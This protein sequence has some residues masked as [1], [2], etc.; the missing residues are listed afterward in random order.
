[1]ATTPDPALDLTLVD[2]VAVIGFDRQAG[3]EV[4]LTAESVAELSGSHSERSKAPL[5]RAYKSTILQVFPRTRTGFPF[6]PEVASLCMPKGLQFF[7]ERKLPDARFHSFVLVREDGTRL[8]GCAFTFYEP[9]LDPEIRQQMFD[10]HLDYIKDV[11]ESE[12]PERHSRVG[13]PDRSS[14]QPGQVSFGQHTLPRN[15]SRRNQSKRTS[16]YDSTNKPIFVAKCLCVLQR[17][18]ILFS[19]ENILLSLYRSVL[20]SR[21]PPNERVDPVALIRW[22]L[23]ELPLPIPGT[24]LQCSYF[25]CDLSVR[26]PGLCELPFFDYPIFELFKIIPVEKL[27]KLFTCFMLEHQILLCSKRLDRLML[28]AECLSTLIFPFRWQL[29]YVPVLP[30]AQLKFI[31]APVPYLMGFCYDDRIPDQIFQ[32][33]VCVL[34]IDARR[35]DHPEDVPAFP[36]AREL[37]AQIEELVQNFDETAADEPFKRAEVPAK[38]RPSSRRLPSTSSCDR[39]P[40]AAAHTREIAA[41]S[42]AGDAQNGGTNGQIDPQWSFKRMSRSFDNSEAIEA[43]MR[44]EV[45]AANEE[46]DAEEAGAAQ[47][48]RVITNARNEKIQRYLNCLAFNSAIR[49]LFLHTFVGLFTS[50]EQ[51][52]AEARQRMGAAQ[53]RASVVVRPVDFNVHEIPKSRPSFVYDVPPPS[54]H[55]AEGYALDLAPNGVFPQFD[56]SLFEAPPLPPPHGAQ[57]RSDSLHPNAN[58]QQAARLAAEL[59]EQR[60]KLRIAASPQKRTPKRR[61]AAAALASGSVQG[62]TNGATPNAATPAQLAH[63][64]WT[65]VEQLLKE[66]KV[67]TKRLLLMKMGKEA[68]QLGHH[69]SGVQGVEE[70]T[71]VAGFCDLLDR[72][73]SSLWANVLSFYEQNKFEEVRSIHKHHPNVSPGTFPSFISTSPPQPSVLWERATRTRTFDRSGRPLEDDEETPADRNAITEIFDSFRSMAANWEKEV[74]DDPTNA[75]TWS[76]SLA[77]VGNFINKLN[78]PLAPPTTGGDFCTLPRPNFGPPWT[79]QKP[80]PSAR[81]ERSD[82]QLHAGSNPP[83]PTAPS[84][85]HSPLAVAAER[86]HE[87]KRSLSRPKSPAYDSERDL[88]PL[89]T[90]IGYDLRNVLRMTEIKTDIGFARAFVRLSLERKLL[91]SHLKAILSDRSLLRELYKRY[92][93]LRSEDER[94][95]FLYHVLS[96]NA[97]DFSCF[98]HTFISTRIQYEVL[99]VS[100]L[101]RFNSAAVW[102]I[103]SGSLGATNTINL[104]PNSLQF[105]FEHKNLGLLTTLR[106]GYNV[107]EKGAKWFLDY[108]IVRNN[109]TAQAFRFNCGRSFGRGVDDG[110]TERVLV[111]ETMRK[112]AARGPDDD[113]SPVGPPAQNMMSKWMSTSMMLNQLGATGLSSGSRPQSP[114]GSVVSEA[115]GRRRSASRTH[116]HRSR[117]PSN[118]PAQQRQ[119][120]NPQPQYNYY[121]ARGHRSELQLNQWDVRVNELQH[122]IGE[123]VN[124]LVKHFLQNTYRSDANLTQLLCGEKGLIVYLEQVFTFGRKENLF[125]NRFFRQQY[126]WDYIEKAFTWFASFISTNGKTFNKETQSIIIYQRHMVSK[127]AQNASVGKEGQIPGLPAVGR[128]LAALLPLLA[129]SPVTREIYD[130]HSI[131]RQPQQL[132]ALSKLLS[133]LDEFTIT[134]EKSLTYGIVV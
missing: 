37:I 56:P 89:P 54:L 75:T 114:A 128:S 94:E 8:N 122:K 69:D 59:D 123:A 109:I 100:T 34:D 52:S 86:G 112:E 104:P 74:A 35:L 25:G 88:P 71:L 29:T 77:R 17:L 4:D 133:A 2:Y 18:P 38:T 113:Q 33:N 106:I 32:S 83:T 124:A 73:K 43:A 107:R 9:V 67:K 108:V 99:F 22:V 46:D 105:T 92:A 97:V 7:T 19:V 13:R 40:K 53:N 132:N 14:S 36:K 80:P 1:M 24:A 121:S 12:A 111:A 95:Q 21:L 96:L 70:N 58:N 130:E 23:H 84:R 131:L 26:R 10:L 48:D 98:T 87:R 119:H 51:F 63:R 72:G 11:A 85:P 76:V 101:D 44:A 79:D 30:Y 57:S 61:T 82:R 5:D 68:L 45:E 116:H 15:V 65:F 64:N 120:A 50:Y 39:T 31:E 81:A 102:I 134:L 60:L 78:I 90:H 16:Y 91:H 103:C 20:D 110:A 42:S 125:S 126:P 55:K 93:F 115:G 6:V 66:T 49:E 47:H 118:E 41:E 127:I 27:V 62:A 117:D 28:V 129:W 3:L